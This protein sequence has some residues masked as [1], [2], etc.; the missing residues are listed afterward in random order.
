M[1]AESLAL[2]RRQLR[3]AQGKQ[4]HAQSRDVGKH[5]AGI[6]KQRQAVGEPATDQ[7]DDTERAGGDQRKSESV[8]IAPGVVP[9]TTVVHSF[10]GDAQELPSL[11]WRFQSRT[12]ALAAQASAS[13]TLPAR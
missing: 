2:R 11:S 1:V 13:G 7:L 10:P 5:V 8:P 3:Q 9:M 4:A 12:R 6:G